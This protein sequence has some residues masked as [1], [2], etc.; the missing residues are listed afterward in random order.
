VAKE[1]LKLTY[2]TWHIKQEKGKIAR[3]K[4]QKWFLCQNTDKNDNYL[5]EIKT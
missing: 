4:N 2:A 1:F 3:L 5:L